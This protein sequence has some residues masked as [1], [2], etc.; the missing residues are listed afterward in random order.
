M[1]HRPEGHEVVGHEAGQPDQANGIHREPGPEIPAPRHLQPEREPAAGEHEVDG[2]GAPDADRARQREPERILAPVV[3]PEPQRQ[4][5]NEQGAEH[6]ALVLLELGAVVHQHRRDRHQP[7]QRGAG[8]KGREAQPGHGQRQRQGGQPTEQ[9]HQAQRPFVG[10]QQDSHQLHQHQ[11]ADRGRLVVGQWFKDQLRKTPV[12]ERRRQQGFVVPEGAV[13]DELLQAQ[14]AARGNDQP[15]PQAV[16]AQQVSHG[17]QTVCGRWCG[18]GHGSPPIR[19]VSG[20]MPTAPV[21]ATACSAEA[22][23]YARELK[24]SLIFLRKT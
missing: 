6:V 16:R 13:E 21:A 10:A 14:G 23:L 17:G 7:H 2:V 4:P 9:G 18:G 11:V 24:R 8:H 22:A 20:P 15:E 3:G 1:R 12:S 19:L 5:Q